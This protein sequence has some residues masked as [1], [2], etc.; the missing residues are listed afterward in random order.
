MKFSVITCTRNSVQTLAETIR[1]V[2]AQRDVEVEH[3][4]VDGGSTDGT[5]ELIGRQCPGAIVI[6]EIIG[7]ISRAMNEGARRATGD[8]IAHLHSDDYYVHSGVLDDVRTGMSGGAA[9]L[10]GRVDQLRA[11][12]IVHDP[13]PLKN[14]TLRR[15]AAGS[16]SIQHPAVFVRRGEFMEAGLFD[17][18]L[19]YAMDIDMWFRLGRRGVPALIDAP[20]AVFRMHPGS[21]STSNVE[22]A[23]AEEWAVRKRYAAWAPLATL[24]F[25]VRRL[26]RLRDVRRTGS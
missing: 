16:V 14:F 18:S 3:I 5:L 11:G 12:V 7:G 13:R 23:R 4:F 1:S 22:Q 2:Q 26:K 19:R 17:E 10:C 21:L 6:P 24:L 9:W 25:G 8:V 20:L 15:Y